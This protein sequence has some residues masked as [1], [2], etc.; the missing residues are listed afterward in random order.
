MIVIAWLLFSQD[1]LSLFCLVL[2]VSKKLKLAHITHA[3]SR[4]V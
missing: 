1:L 4:L 3:I 2:H